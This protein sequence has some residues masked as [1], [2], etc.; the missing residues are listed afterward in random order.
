MLIP[1][2]KLKESGSVRVK[3]KVYASG[4]GIREKLM[5]MLMLMHAPMKKNEANLVSPSFCWMLSTLH[6]NS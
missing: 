1:S 3:I 4:R 2:T 5:L 6:T